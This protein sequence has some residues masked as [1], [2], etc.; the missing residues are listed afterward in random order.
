MGCTWHGREIYREILQ[1]PSCW[2]ESHT[3][4]DAEKRC[5]TSEKYECEDLQVQ[6]LEINKLLVSRLKQ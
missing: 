3:I 1:F 2:N 4:I 5:P 6:G